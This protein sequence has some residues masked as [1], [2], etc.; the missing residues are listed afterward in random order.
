[1]NAQAAGFMVNVDHSFVVDSNLMAM[2]LSDVE[3]AAA[4]EALRAREKQF[5]VQLAEMCG[6]E[7]MQEAAADPGALP[8][9]DF[10]DAGALGIFERTDEVA[11]GKPVF[12][13]LASSGKT[14]LWYASDGS[15]YV[16]SVATKNANRATGHA[17]TVKFGLEHP[18][19]DANRNRI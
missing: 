11:N 6:V 4:K 16:S 10:C 19:G 15:W 13:L 8:P 2:P 7:I 17:C 14:V 5:E 9:P 3:L 1:M 12:V 18:V